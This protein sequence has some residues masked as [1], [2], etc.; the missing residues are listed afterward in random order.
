MSKNSPAKQN[1]Q[2]TSEKS[3]ICL[4]NI[5]LKLKFNELLYK[6]KSKQMQQHIKILLINI[7]M[8][9]NVFRQTHCLSSGA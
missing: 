3:R 4:E 6:E 7:Y 2:A 1:L 8:K 9:F 5:M